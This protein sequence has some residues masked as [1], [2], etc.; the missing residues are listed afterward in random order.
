MKA[1]LGAAGI[2]TDDLRIHERALYPWNTNLQDYLFLFQK[3]CSLEVHVSKHSM[4]SFVMFI[5]KVIIL[6]Q[7][8]PPLFQL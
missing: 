6:I 8:F 2:R 4:K 1:N 5:S 3:Y 7:C